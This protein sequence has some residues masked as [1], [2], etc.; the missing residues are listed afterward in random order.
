MF[1]KF[2]TGEA[3]QTSRFAA[4]FRRMRHFNF[5][6]FDNIYTFRRFR[7][8]TVETPPKSFALYLH[9]I[10]LAGLR[11]IIVMVLYDWYCK[12]S[13]YNICF[14]IVLNTF[15][16]QC[17]GQKWLCFSINTFVCDVLFINF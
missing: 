12:L 1:Q 5:Q 3:I 9:L 10:V 17:T 16:Y 13:E 15:I 2:W 8:W 11:I 14:Y 6:R 4:S 7:I